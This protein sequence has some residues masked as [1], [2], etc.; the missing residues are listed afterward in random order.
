MSKKEIEHKESI[1][2]YIGPT[3]YAYISSEGLNRLVKEFDPADPEKNI[4]WTTDINVEI[5][6]VMKNRGAG[7]PNFNFNVQVLKKL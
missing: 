1:A 5:P 3:E 6:I 4:V 7:N 2:R